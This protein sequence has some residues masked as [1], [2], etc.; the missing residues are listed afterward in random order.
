MKRLSLVVLAFALLTAFTLIESQPVRVTLNNRPLFNA[1]VIQGGTQPGAQNAIIAV[2]LRDFL[3]VSGAGLTME[4]AFEQRGSEL[5]AT[6]KMTFT[7][8][9]K[10]KQQPT[11]VPAVQST[12]KIKYAPGQLIAAQKAGR[13]GT[14]ITITGPGGRRLNYLN[15][16]DVANAM[17]DGSVR[18]SFSGGVKPPATLN[19][20]AAANG[21]LIGLNQQ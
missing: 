19:L 5:W 21:I 17:G 8:T 9:V 6:G 3:T 13:I 10:D 4:P 12:M 7:S 16:H 2:L 1:V 20:R 11:L 14:I 18:P 15:L